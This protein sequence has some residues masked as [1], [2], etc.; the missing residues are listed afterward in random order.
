[1]TDRNTSKMVKRINN[2]AAYWEGRVSGALK[3]TNEADKAR[4]IQA[5]QRLK[6][7]RKA[8]RACK[9]GR[10]VAETTI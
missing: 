4:I 6:S 2:A 7:V 1:M 9:M 8:A 3:Q 10:H 5:Y